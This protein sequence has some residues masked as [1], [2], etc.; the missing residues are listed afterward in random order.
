MA[1]AR[2]HLVL[3]VTFLMLAPGA[4]ADVGET[5]VDLDD[6]LKQM[7]DTMT[8]DL[9]TALKKQK[10]R[11]GSEALGKELE[12]RFKLEPVGKDDKPL[13]VS[14]VTR[15]YGLQVKMASRE[16][17]FGFQISGD[18]ELVGKMED[19]INI[20]FQSNITFQKGEVSGQVGANGSAIVRIGESARLAV[21][22]EKTLVVRVVEKE[23]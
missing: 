21:L 17:T 23:K 2:K 20:T 16:T 18:L 13:A 14:V 4:I 1:A 5:S 6:Q 7:L 19:E 9:K 3:L 8:R 12:L 10:W 22:G 15:R 11:Q